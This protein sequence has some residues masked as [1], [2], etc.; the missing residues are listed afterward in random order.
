MNEKRVAENKAKGTAPSS[1]A[2][3]K[4]HVTFINKGGVPEFEKAELFYEDS[5][6]AKLGDG[7][8]PQAVNSYE[9][10]TWNVKV[11]GKTVKTWVVNEE[12]IQKY[13][14]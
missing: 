8:P 9:G 5:F 3:A 10:Q 11:D 6:W 4:K 7:D 2:P 13:T 1:N 12:D 14:L